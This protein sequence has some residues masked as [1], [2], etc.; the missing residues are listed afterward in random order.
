MEG[1]KLREAMK[2]GKE[3][4]LAEK[5]GEKES[6]DAPGKPDMCTADELHYV[7]VPGTDWR[8]ALWRYLPSKNVR[9]F[10]LKN[11]NLGGKAE[12]NLLFKISD[13]LLQLLIFK[14]CIGNSPMLDCLL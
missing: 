7:P 12:L 4:G 2:T 11:A 13:I 10:K 14:D 6:A 9:F 5:K 8:L 1:E 3:V